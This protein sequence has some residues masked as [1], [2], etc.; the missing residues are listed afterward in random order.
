MNQRTVYKI[1]ILIGLVWF[2]L[3]AETV[4]GTVVI[5]RKLTPTRVTAAVP[6]YQRGTTVELGADAEDDPLAVERSRVVVYVEGPGPA[7]Q[8]VVA[9]MEQQN[10]RFTQETVVISAG[11]R[12]SFP[13]MDPIFH[14]VFSLSKPKS[15]DLGNYKK[16]EARTVTFPEPGVVYVNCHL[17]PNMT[18]AIIVTPNRWY[19]KADRTGHFTLD[20]L[21]PGKYTLVAWHKTAGFFRQTVEVVAGKGASTEF[22]IPLDVDG[23]PLTSRTKGTK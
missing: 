17:H 16:G 5:H 18:G 7:G 20:G 15:F 19:T 22:L 2:P 6:M 9:K 10:R 14:N 4:T 8:P 23:S 11:S 13:N 3:Q 21:P 12:V 1:A